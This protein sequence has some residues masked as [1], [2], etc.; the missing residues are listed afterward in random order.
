MRTRRITKQ[1]WLVYIITSAKKNNGIISMRAMIEWSGKNRSIVRTRIMHVIELAATRG[2]TITCN[3][4]NVKKEKQIEWA[5]CGC[6]PVKLSEILPDGFAKHV[7]KNPSIF[8]KYVKDY[9]I[10]QGWEFSY[11]GTTQRFGR[12]YRTNTPIRIKT[13]NDTCPI[14]AMLKIKDNNGKF[15]DLLFNHDVIVT[16]EFKKK[17]IT[18]GADLYNNDEEIRIWVEKVWAEEKEKYR[19]EQEQKNKE[20]M[21]LQ[22]F[23]KDMNLGAI[24]KEKSNK[25]LAQERE[26]L[27]AFEVFDI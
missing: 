22:E 15:C 1:Q 18:R 17:K 10:G 20:E 26:L 16:K 8:W 21:E 4:L 19:L 12:F 11:S 14:W 27:S 23:Y 24:Y 2:Y 3:G 9:L 25:V 5:G 6:I 13:P 7:R